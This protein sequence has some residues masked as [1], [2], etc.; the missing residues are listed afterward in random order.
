MTKEG[1]AMRVNIKTDFKVKDNDIRAI[2]LIR[3]AIRISSPH[4]KKAN[5]EFSIRQNIMPLDY[6]LVNP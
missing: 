1:E 4:M 3:E 2:V 5:L 6:D